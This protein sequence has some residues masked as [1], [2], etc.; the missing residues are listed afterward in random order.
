[1]FGYIFVRINCSLQTDRERKR[2]RE[3]K[4]SSRTVNDIDKFILVVYQRHFLFLAIMITTTTTTTTIIIST[5][6]I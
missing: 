6:I 3:I 4:N 2:E 1:M 5:I